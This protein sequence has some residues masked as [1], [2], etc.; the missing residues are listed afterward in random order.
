MA[1]RRDTLDDLLARHGVPVTEF[2]K[3]AG[4]PPFTLLRLRKGERVPRI[5]TIAK[6]AK[7]LGLDAAV[8]RAAIEASRKAR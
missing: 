6:L 5:A 3:D 4:I 8:V 2:A 7:A 1:K